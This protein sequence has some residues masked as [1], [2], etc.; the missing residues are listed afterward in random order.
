MIRSITFLIIATMAGMSLWFMAAAILPDM[1][2]EGGIG[3]QR[4]ALLSSVVPLGFALGAFGIAAT[5]ITDRFDP[6]YVFAVCALVA[7]I[8]N[9]ALIVAPIGG[10][11]AVVLRTITGAALA[12]TW[13]VTM[14]IAVGWSIARRGSLMGLVAAALMVGQSAPYLMAW[15]GGTDWRFALSLGSGLSVVG[16]LAV[17]ATSLGPYHARAAQFRTSALSLAWTDRRIRAAILG[18]LGHMWE[19]VAF[20][21]WAGVITA[22]SYAPHMTTAEANSLG[23]LT[24]FL[25]ILVAAPA[26]LVTGVLADRVG[27]ARVAATALAISGSAAV[28]TALTFEGPVIVTFVLVLIWGAAVVPDS[29]QFSAIVSDHAPP[30]MVGSLL[31]FQAS[32]GFLLAAATVQIAPFVAEA[33]GWPILMCILALGPVFGIRAIWPELR[34]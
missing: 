26:C 29:P 12:G 33:L 31:T 8:L 19:F 3:P 27:K 9:V 11:L 25:C 22:L 34:Q 15:I 2:A 13:P 18:Y 6:R 7:A 28:L 30:D 16:A 14:K 20:W 21:S 24:A 23:K 32:L 10:W 4:L 1:A 5:G 17:L